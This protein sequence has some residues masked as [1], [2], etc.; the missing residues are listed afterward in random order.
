MPKI[1]KIEKMT[2]NRY[3]NMY[4]YK[5]ENEKGHKGDYFVASRAESVEKLKINGS[6]KDT[7]AVIIYALYGENHDRVVLEKQYRYPIGGYIYEFPAGLIDK[8]ETYRQAAVREMHEETGLDLEIKECD[9]MFENSRYTSVG[10]SDESV[11]IVYGYAKGNVSSDYMESGEDIKVI[12]ADRKEVGRIL[13]EEEVSM[14]C[15]YHL[16]HF[17]TDEEPF[18]FLD[19]NKVM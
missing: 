2:D 17:L 15:A 16:M 3:L 7:D 11:S 6:R 12:L 14:N 19:N 10:M 9:P 18:S 4:R 5:V 8:G 13:K 1:N